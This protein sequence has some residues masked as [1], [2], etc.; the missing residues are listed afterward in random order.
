MVK[1]EVY[2][3][4]ICPHCPA[5]KRLVADVASRY[6]DDVEVEEIDTF[7]PEGIQRGMTNDVMAVPTVFIDG[8]KKFV[9]F[10]FAE[11]DLVA[12]IEE[13]ING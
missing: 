2:F 7:T 10:P 4:P 6:G 13:A 8:E 9:G 3:S 5:A 11:E 1:I 12:S